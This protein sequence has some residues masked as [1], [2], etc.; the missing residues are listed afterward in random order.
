MAGSR[1][2]MDLRPLRESPAFRRLWAGSVLSATGGQMTNFAVLLQVYT[3]THSSIAV[4]GVGW[5][6]RRRCRRSP[7]A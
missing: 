2:L 1:L 5:A 3:L 4:G 7:S 6:W